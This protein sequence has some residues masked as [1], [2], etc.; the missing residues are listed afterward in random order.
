MFSDD[1]DPKDQ[2]HKYIT[3]SGLDSHDL[4]LYLQNQ[5]CLGQ[6]EVKMGFPFLCGSLFVSCLLHKW[7]GLGDDLLVLL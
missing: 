6:K 3:E 5:I 7:G 2:N 4:L 1:I